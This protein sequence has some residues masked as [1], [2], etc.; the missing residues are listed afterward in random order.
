MFSRWMIDEIKRDDSLDYLKILKGLIEIP[1]PVGKKLLVDFLRG[2]YKN[3]S[4]TKN[5]LDELSHFDSLS[6]SEDKVYS[7]IENLIHNGM[8]EIVPS[9]FNKFIKVLQVPLRGRNEIIEP[10]L[11]KSK[12][13]AHNFSEIGEEDEKRFEDYSEFLE[14]FNDGQKKAITSPSK[15]ILCVA[16]AGSG[17]TT[18]LTKRI[19]FLVRHKGVDP[20][21]ILAITFT[22][23][24]RREMEN[25]LES[26]G[27]KTNIATFN[28]FC[29]RILRE[30]GQK[31][32]DRPVRVQSYADKL[33]AMNMALENLGI[34]MDDAVDGYFSESQKK[35]KEPAQLSVGMMN[36]CFTVLEYF[37]TRNEDLYDFS[38]EADEKD[39][40][41]A[42]RVYKICKYLD[43]HMK[44]Q[45]MRDFTDQLLDTLR[46]FSKHPDLIP[47]FEHVLV[48]EYQDVNST[49]IKLLS[50]LNPPNLFAVGD[51]RQSI[52]GWRGSDINYILDFEE[53]YPDAE[54]V[55]LV[56]NYRSDKKIV[57]FMNENISH[58][59]LP[60]L[61]HH[62]EFDSEVKII[63]FSSEEEERNF[64]VKSILESEAPREEIFVL[65]RTN[66]QLKEVSA[67]LKERGIA[68]VLKT[69]EVRR[70]KEV[71]KGEITLATVHA[72]K[73]LEARQVFVIG[74]TEQNFPCKAS[75]HPVIEMIKIE[76]YDKIEE[77]KRLFYVAISRAKE[78]LTISY[79]GS[80]PTH[81]L[82][83][84]VVKKF[85]EESQ[86]KVGAFDEGVGEINESVL[87]GLKNWRRNKSEEL[88]VP[89][90]VVMHDKT[91]EEISRKLPKT[92]EDLSKINGLGPSKL[93]K[94]GSQI[95]EIVE[96]NS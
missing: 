30:H 43:E 35:W 27:V 48:D 58:M 9:D 78:K 32:Y 89:A 7:E 39:Q 53:D 61:E 46:L 67:K 8:I 28:S 5:N 31:I 71:G 72:I 45:G 13:F 92:S 26:L 64:V 24:A 77:E 91:L 57:D 47:K 25:R 41:N 83:E 59:G 63:N 34:G 3:K 14:G 6:W 10:S 2:N 95:L 69:D 68:H 65:A 49:Q 17:K 70:P 86:K 23:K 33:M 4:V 93:S 42:K 15:K 38:K 22:R 55:H 66:R 56:K 90:F 51:P 40:Q 29:E 18:V 80:K 81:F 74:A 85:G 52:Y 19:E 20:S 75:D 82:S 16:G 11:N 44:I 12:S 96:E 76:D 50:F 84:D 37:K 60:K 1:F 62:H 94:Y 79:V 73:G 54:I 87:E 21:K 88:D 36:D